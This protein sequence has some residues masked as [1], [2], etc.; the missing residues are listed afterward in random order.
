[1]RPQPVIVNRYCHKIKLYPGNPCTYQD[2][3][4][5]NPKATQSWKVVR[6][7]GNFDTGVQQGADASAQFLGTELKPNQMAVTKS[8]D[9][10]PGSSQL[11]VKYY[12]ATKGRYIQV[13]YQT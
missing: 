9:I 4:G 1:M 3:M 5:K 7:I 13:P 12:E 2:Q 8:E 11:N 10:K 6:K